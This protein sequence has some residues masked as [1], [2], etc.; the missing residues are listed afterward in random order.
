MTHISSL[1]LKV[2]SS[3]KVSIIDVRKFH[4]RKDYMITFGPSLNIFFVTFDMLLSLFRKHYIKSNTLSLSIYKNK[5]DL[6]KIFDQLYL[7]FFLNLLK[8][9]ENFF[10]LIGV[11][12]WCD[13][14]G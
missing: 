10:I 5:Y 14:A 3:I 8:F 7:N 12:G 2:D 13:G 9:Y 11:V 6:N 1:G 4:P